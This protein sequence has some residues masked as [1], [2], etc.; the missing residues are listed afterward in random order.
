MVNVYSKPL[1][2]DKNRMWDDIYVRKSSLGGYI[3]C[4]LRDFSLV[5]SPY[6]RRS[7]VGSGNSSNNAKCVAFSFS[8][9]YISLTDLTLLGR[10]FTWFQLYGGIVSMLY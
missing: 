10:K 3:W 7:Y 8:I 1:L 4:V 6:E 2:A 5:S 9:S